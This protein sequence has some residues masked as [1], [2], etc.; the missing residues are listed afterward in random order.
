[1]QTTNGAARRPTHPSLRHSRDTPEE[2][3]PWLP[4]L[5]SSPRNPRTLVPSVSLAGARQAPTRAQA[6][7]SGRKAV[8]RAGVGRCELSVGRKCSWAFPRGRLPTPRSPG[9]QIRPGL[10]HLH[11]LGSVGNGIC[12]TFSWRR[13]FAVRSGPLTWDPPWDFPGRARGS[14]LSTISFQ[15]ALVWRGFSFKHAGSI[16]G[17]PE[18]G[19]LKA[20]G[21]LSVLAAIHVTSYPFPC[22]SIPSITLG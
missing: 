5:S 2:S 22:F 20:Q 18:L 21:C 15:Y 19:L 7:P 4:A 6:P 17:C 9:A 8:A 11:P 16:R 12:C 1:M 13:G 14:F 10:H 3:L